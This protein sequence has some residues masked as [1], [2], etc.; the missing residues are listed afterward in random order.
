L[1]Q[2]S[3]FSLEVFNRD[4]PTPATGPWNLWLGLAVLILLLGLGLL[5]RSFMDQVENS[6][7]RSH[8]LSNIS[9]ELK[10]PL[11]LIRLYTDTLEAGRVSNDTDRQKFLGI[12]GRESK[13]L[14]HLIDN[15]LDIQRIEQERKSYSYAQVRP[16]KVVRNTVEA[17]RYQLTEDGFTLRLDIDEDLPLL[18]LDEEAIAQAIINLLD[19]AAKYSD[20]VK[21]IRVRC[22]RRDGEVHLSVQDRGIGIPVREQTKIF[23]NFY[24]VEKS[25]VHDVKGS[26]LGLPVVAHV[27]RAHGGRVEVESTPGKGSTFTLRL[28]V[29]FDPERA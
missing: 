3:P 22:A 2:A 27:A 24:R 28:P 10:T 11:S 29:D 7:L 6:R 15:I 16:D 1:G 25:L 20:T 12:I 19:N 9:H 21:D 18:M 23:Q 8:L 26:G 17:Y 13:R 4:A 14:T 5:S